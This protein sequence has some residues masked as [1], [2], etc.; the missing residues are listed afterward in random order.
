M[1]NENIV[2]SLP[3]VE[4]ISELI[5]SLSDYAIKSAREQWAKNMSS[6]Y[7]TPRLHCWDEC[8]WFELSK[9]RQVVNYLLSV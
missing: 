9:D 8:V 2:V 4:K 1:E 7:L 5:T 6:V 3:D